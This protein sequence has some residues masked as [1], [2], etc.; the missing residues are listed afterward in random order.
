MHEMIIWVMRSPRRIIFFL[1]IIIAILGIANAV[2]YEALAFT[3]GLYAPAALAVVAIV[4]A[5]LSLGFIGANVLGSYFY[6]A[7]TRTL[8]TALASWVGSFAYLFFASTTLGIVTSIASIG[9]YYFPL[10]SLGAIFFAIALLVSTYGIV[11]ARRIVVTRYT[12][13]LPH[14]PAAWKNKRAVWISDLHLGQVHGPASAAR[15]ASVIQ[16]L[17]PEIIF[18]GGD[19]YDGTRAP[20]PSYLVRP[21]STLKAPWG[22]FYITGNHEEFGDSSAFLA[23]VRGSGMRV[24]CDEMIDIEGLQLVGVDYHNANTADGF[25]EI[26]NGLKLDSAQPSLLLKHEPNNLS[27]AEEAGISLQISGHTHNGQQ[28]PFGYLA[29]LSYKGYAYGLKD[30]GPLQVLVSSGVGS[31]GPPLRVGSKAEVVEITFV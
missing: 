8:Y 17:A 10:R 9:R 6:N 14:V 24:L 18:I 20:D 28:W 3:F 19:L 2:V 4:L 1:A 5:T 12:V 13:A 7:L 27:V 25:K 11:N 29:N 30:H 31:W 26:L 21:L 16:A 15:V 23:A 22:V